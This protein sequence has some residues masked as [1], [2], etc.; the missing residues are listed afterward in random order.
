MFELSTGV[1]YRETN[2]RSD[3]A[4]IRARRVL[5]AASRG[6]NTENYFKAPTVLK[7]DIYS[8][9]KGGESTQQGVGANSRETVR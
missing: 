9:L 5:A 6:E 1:D 7:E 2:V 3:I 4:V 8:A